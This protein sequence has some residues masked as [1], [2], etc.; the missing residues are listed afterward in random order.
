[1]LGQTT[2]IVGCGRTDAG[3]HASEYYAQFQVEKLFDYNPVFR[4]NKMLPDD[5][6][7]EKCM[8]VSDKAHTQ[9]DAFSRTYEYYIHGQKNA[10]LSELSSLYSFKNMD[11]EKLK[12]AAKLIVETTDFRTFCKQPDVYKHHNCYLKNCHWE[13]DETAQ[14]MVFSITANRFLRGMIRLLV[15]NMLE[16]GYGRISLEHFEKCLKNEEKP[17]FYRAAY[18]QGL[19]LARVK[20]RY[21]D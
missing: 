5:I 10:F 9:F 6:S 8:E 11:F 17:A 2:T 3:V 20:Y 21:L 16:V 1:M 15:G 18:P 19:Y 13:M 14:K 4:L 12:A 7:I